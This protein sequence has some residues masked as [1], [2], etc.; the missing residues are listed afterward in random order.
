MG[1]SFVRIDIHVVFSTL[2][3]IPMIDDHIARDVH[4]FMAWTINGEGARCL[5]VGGMPDHV[6]ILIRARADSA[7]SDLM[8]AVKSRTTGFIKRQFGKSEF[9]WQPGY[10]AFS[11]S[12]SAIADTIRY[13]ENQREHHARESYVDEARRILTANGWKP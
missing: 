10:G 6:H 11:V 8:S 7:F 4:S 9:A 13:I 12:E 1:S 2:R 5:A 3:R